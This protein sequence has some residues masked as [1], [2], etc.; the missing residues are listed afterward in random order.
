MP[1]FTSQLQE[2]RQ[3]L[4]IGLRQ[5]LQLLTHTQ[6]D[7]AAAAQLFKQELT[8]LVVSKTG[9]ERPVAE[10]HLA[11]ANYDVNQALQ[12]IRAELYTLTERILLRYPTDQAQAL[13]RIQLAIEG[14]IPLA[15]NHWVEVGELQ[16]L[17]RPQACFILLCEWLDYQ[18]WEGLTDALFF[19]LD[20]VVAELRQELQQFALA[21]TLLAMRVRY[22]ALQMRYA[23]ASSEKAH[24]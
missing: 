24:R 8:D 4:P 14:E 11:L 2:L 15:R 16:K 10:Q 18:E 20:L 9:V 3:L 13:S 19:H 17:N 5:A 21:D 7:V 23:T 12:S 1:P 6:G 22:A